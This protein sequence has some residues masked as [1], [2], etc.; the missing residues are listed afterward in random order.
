MVSTEQEVGRAC[1]WTCKEENNA[2]F[3]GQYVE[4][5]LYNIRGRRKYRVPPGQT[6][7]RAQPS[8]RWNCLWALV[9]NTTL[10]RRTRTGPERRFVRRHRRRESCGGRSY[11]YNRGILFAPLD[12]LVERKPGVLITIHGVENFVYPLYARDGV[13]SVISR[14]GPNKR[15]TFSGVS[16]SSGSLTIDPVIL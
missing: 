11:L 6:T 4:K 3:V 5:N 2:S 9:D 10:G 8:R 16:S 14:G 7:R 13:F 15:H 1:P 12:K